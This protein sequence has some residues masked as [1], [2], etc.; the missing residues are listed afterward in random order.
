MHLD[1][2]F[3]P[4]FRARIR[5]LRCQIA[6]FCHEQLTG[7]VQTVLGLCYLSHQRFGNDICRRL[8]KACSVWML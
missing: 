8:D 5:S 4:K 3:Q 2:K 1:S 6:A 7:F